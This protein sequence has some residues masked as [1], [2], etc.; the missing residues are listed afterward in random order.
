[1]K[2]VRDYSSEKKRYA[3]P[4]SE[5][6]DVLVESTLMDTSIPAPPDPSGDERNIIWDD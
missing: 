1:M 2:T 5:M 6:L 3:A 4:S